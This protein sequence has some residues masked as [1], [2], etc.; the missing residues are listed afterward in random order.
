TN[1][2]VP[3]EVT[4]LTYGTNGF[5]QKYG[6]T[7][8]AASFADSDYH[9]VHTVTAVG[10][11]H[12]DTT[13]KKFGTASAQFDG[14]GDQLTMPYSTDWAQMAYEKDFTLDFWMYPTDRTPGD[15][16]MSCQASGKQTFEINFINDSPPLIRYA[17]WDGGAWTNVDS[18]EVGADAWHHYAI[19]RSNGYFTTY[20]DGVPGTAV[21]DPGDLISEP[22]ATFN[23][24]A[25]YYGTAY[26]GYIDEVRLSDTARWTSDF[27]A[28]L[29][30][31][32][33]TADVN[34]LLLLHMDGSDGGTTFTDSSW[35]GVGTPGHRITANGDVTNT[36][37]QSKVGDSSIKFDGTGDFL[38]IPDSTD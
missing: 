20:V 17:A 3:I 24:G 14:T 10:D 4:G 26:E 5:Y 30:S 32:A 18:A 22:G 6:A 33:Y 1:Q 12:T 35:V 7:E 31:S 16:I 27:S 13:V 34:T 25:S 19:V 11:V 2:W 28:S 38:E 23:I 9:N 29:P 37:A 36:R 8:L 21:A 15:A